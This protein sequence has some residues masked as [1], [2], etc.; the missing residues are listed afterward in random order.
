MYRITMTVHHGRVFTASGEGDY[1][2][3]AMT[4]LMTTPVGIGYGPSS[5]FN[6]AVVLTNLSRHGTSQH[7][8]ADY[9]MEEVA[10]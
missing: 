10:V 6:R 4:R 3:E 1:P 5:N 7:G 8:W 9:R 2:H